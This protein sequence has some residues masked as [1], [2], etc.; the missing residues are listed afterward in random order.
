MGCNARMFST[1][2]G[3][4]VA[5]AVVK[6]YWQFWPFWKWDE[7]ERFCCCLG[8]TLRNPQ[9]PFDEAHLYEAPS[10]PEVYPD[11][12]VGSE[13]GSMI[14]RSMNFPGGDDEQTIC[15]EILDMVRCPCPASNGDSY[16]D[17][18]SGK[19]KDFSKIVQFAATT[20]LK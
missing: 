16:F 2:T 12:V 19:F 13:A 9:A 4:L 7:E 15:E 18:R 20:V 8:N 6:N 17:M 5:D 10:M 14:R 1:R 11:E 3:Q